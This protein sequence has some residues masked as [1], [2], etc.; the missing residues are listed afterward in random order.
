MAFQLELY[1]LVHWLVLYT[2]YIILSQYLIKL[3]I[4]MRA[5]ITVTTRHTLGVHNEQRKER[6]GKSTHTLYISMQ[7]T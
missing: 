3:R 2:C 7:C 4:I 6:E 5:S 1:L